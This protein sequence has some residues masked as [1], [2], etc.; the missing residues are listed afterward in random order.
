[1]NMA[2]SRVILDLLWA[3][4]LANKNPVLE[5]GDIAQDPKVTPNLASTGGWGIAKGNPMDHYS[6]HAMVALTADQQ[7]MVE[8][9]AKGIFRPC[10]N[11]STYFPDCNHGMAMLGLLELLAANNI[12]KED[13]YK[14]ALDVN[15]IWFPQTY[16]DLAV[17][18]AENGT[19]W[20]KIDAKTVLGPEYS[21]ASGYKQ[22]RGLIKS[23]PQPQKGGGGCG[24]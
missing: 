21:S 18:F 14:I 4:G 23:L 3:F 1:M 19:S 15:S 9:M 13:A 8:D 22:T 11:N 2:N 24:I 7:K 16:Q 12:S 10:C 6:A 5:Q 17:Y 20:D